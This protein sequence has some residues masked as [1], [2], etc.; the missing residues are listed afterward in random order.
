MDS[1]N[2]LLDP[3]TSRELEILGL[4]AEGLSNREIA[5]KLVIAPGTVKWYNKQ[6]YSKLNVHSREQAVEKSRSTGI[7]PAQPAVPGDH[8]SLAAHNLPAQITSFVGRQREI[9]EVKKLLAGS[10]LLTLSGPPGTGKTRLALQ[11]ASQVLHQFKDGVYFVELAPI[12]DAQVAYFKDVLDANPDVRWT[13]CFIHAPPYFTLTSG[14][15][16]PGNF[17]KIETLLGNRPYTVFSAHTH[18]YDYE[19]R[20]GRDFITTSTSGGISIPRPGAIDHILWVTLD[21]EGPKI[22]NLLMNGIMD[23]KGPPNDDDLMEIGLYRPRV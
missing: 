18:I 11:V 21:N 14:E 5:Q 3:L 12:S 1:S 9:S 15:K 4:L 16:D 2:N 13:F 8:P 22:A 10:R 17:A 23:K 20:D 6:I 19:K 7:L